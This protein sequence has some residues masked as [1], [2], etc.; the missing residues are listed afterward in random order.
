[1]EQI[2]A[3]IS[4]ANRYLS[5]YLFA[6]RYLQISEISADICRY[7]FASRYLSADICRYLL[8]IS[9]REQISADIC[10]QNPDIC[11]YLFANRYLQISADILFANRYLRAV[12]VREQIR[13]LQ[14]S[15]REQIS[16]D[17]CRYLLAADICMQISAGI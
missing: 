15:V 13:Y 8:K 10:S 11:R 4:A 5:R 14:I 12:S 3:D 6:S 1:M 9:A 2:S 7:L 17:I 16:A